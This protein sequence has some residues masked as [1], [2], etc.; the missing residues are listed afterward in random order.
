MA[1]IIMSMCGDKAEHDITPVFEYDDEVLS[2][3]WNPVVSLQHLFP[4][5]KQV[6]MPA[7]L[8]VVDAEQFLRKMYGCLS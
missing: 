6:A 4:V 7:E 5:E 3:G 1:T 8:A 2:S